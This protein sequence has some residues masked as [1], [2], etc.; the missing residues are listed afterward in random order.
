MTRN[1]WENL[2]ARNL[3]EKAMDFIAVSDQS[4]YE[5]FKDVDK[6]DYDGISMIAEN[7]A[8]EIEN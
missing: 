6:D 5:F 7:L 3:S 1:E 4:I 8:D 2:D